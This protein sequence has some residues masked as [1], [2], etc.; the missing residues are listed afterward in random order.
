MVEGTEGSHSHKEGPIKM[1]KHNMMCA[2]IDTGKN[3]LD[4]AIAGSAERCSFANIAQGH[5]EMIGLVASAL[6][7]ADRHRGE[8]RL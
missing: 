7:R 5:A 4:V 2:G 8:R 1:S 6:H 3:K